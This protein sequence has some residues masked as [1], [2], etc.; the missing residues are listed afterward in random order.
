MKCRGF[1]NFFVIQI[2]ILSQRAKLEHTSSLSTQD[3]C[4][5]FPKR[6]HKEEI[7]FQEL[8]QPGRGF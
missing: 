5:S 2:I 8:Q 6:I 7:K 4:S 3:V 1:K